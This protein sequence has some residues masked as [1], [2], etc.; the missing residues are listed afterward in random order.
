MLGDRTDR[1]ILI[2]ILLGIAVLGLPIVALPFGR[3]QAI[4]AVVGKIIVEGGVPYRDALDLKPPGIHLVY[5][6]GYLLSGRE[7]WGPR[8]LDLLSILTAVTALFLLL[9]PCGRLA[10]TLGAVHLGVAYVGCFGYWHLTQPES[11]MIPLVLW[12]LVLFRDSRGGSSRLLGAGACLGTAVLL[13]YTAI[14]F[15]PLLLLIGEGRRPLRSWL[16]LLGGIVAPLV[17]VTAYLLA[18]GGFR[19][20]WLVQTEFNPGYALLFSVGFDRA[21]ELSLMGVKFFATS[22]PF[23]SV[24]PAI[25]VVSLLALGS[26]RGRALPLVG[27][28]AAFAGIAAQAKYFDYHWLPM[29]PFLAWVTGAGWGSMLRR[30][31]ARPALLYSLSGALLLVATYTLV[32]SSSPLRTER[33]PALRWLA[34]VDSR[35]TFYSNDVF[36]RFGVGDYSLSATL[37]AAEE[38]ARLCPS[39][40]SVFVWGFEPLVYLRAER[41]PASRFIYIAP[42]LAPWCP[43]E[44]RR[45]LVR[46]LFASP[47]DVLVVLSE[48]ALPWVSGTNFDSMQALTKVRDLVNL[49]D[50]RYRPA[51]RIE[52]FTFF[53]REGD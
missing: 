48:D 2:A 7:F 38:T 3:D 44:W 50:R 22:K 41:R 25:G 13:K 43:P 14:L 49:I 46:G 37:T 11:F 12:S 42:L 8:L 45:E 20:F 51:G 34:G 36:G 26:P 30:F 29:L 21:A 4:F 10:S 9:R 31:S 24:P 32:L 53:R 16:P 15:L 47:P 1:A 17:V 33:W 28:L 40:G 18:G 27:L 19:E 6:L 35:E 23:L 5:A 39:D 52:H